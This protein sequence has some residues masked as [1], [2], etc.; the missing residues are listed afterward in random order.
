MKYYAA[1]YYVLT[2]LNRKLLNFILVQLFFRMHAMIPKVAA[3]RY[4]HYI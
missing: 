2:H 4:V 1:Y 3:Q